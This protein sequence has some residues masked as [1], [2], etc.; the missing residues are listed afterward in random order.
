MADKLIIKSSP[1]VIS[2]VDTQS[3]MRDVLIAMAPALIASVLVFGAQA[4]LLCAVCVG[5]C[6][7][8][9][10]A[11][12]RIMKRESTIGDLSAAV[13]GLLLAFNLPA[14]FPLWMAVI[15]SFFAIVIVKQLFGGVGQNFANPAISA[16]IFLMI[17]FAT[18]MTSWLIPSRAEGGIEL[19][20]GATPLALMWDNKISLLPS[21]GDMFFGLRGG[22]LGE[23]CTLALLLGG[24]YLLA[25]RIIT[26]AIPLAFL[27]TIAVMSLL[28][29]VDPL[30]NLLAGG[31]MLG[32][33]FMATDYTTSPST[34]KGKIIF[35]IGCG[36]ITMIIRVYGSYPEGV[37]FAILFMNILTPHI[38]SLTRTR[39]FSTVPPK[40]A[41]KVIKEG[42]A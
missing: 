38:N 10:Y 2:V 35:A 24:A 22:C 28:L 37:S 7:L 26:P 1:H 33:F 13:T 14:G 20:A 39:P 12:V 25:R 5:S 9:E 6:V 21:L 3:I 17:S 29:G 32:A 23:T 36:L 42:K 34:E 15:G 4:F 11:S 30:Y 16:R 27:G 18:P 31:A 40:K 41:K 8:F 19:V